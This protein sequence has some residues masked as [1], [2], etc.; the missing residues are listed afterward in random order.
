MALYSKGISTGNTA[1]IMKSTFQ[2]RYSKSTI[3]AITESTLE[4]VK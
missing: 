2:N 4:E 3:S 1:E